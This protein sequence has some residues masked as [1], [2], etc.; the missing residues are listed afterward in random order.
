MSIA[1]EFKTFALRGNL[2]DLAIGVVIG[3]AFGKVVTAFI[4]GLIMPLVGTLTGGV[5]FNNKFIPL[6]AKVAD[7]VKAN[8]TLPLD[9]AKKLGAVWAYGSFITVLIDFLI[10]AFVIFLVI[11]AMNKLQKKEAEAPAATPEPTQSELLLTEIRD[12]LKRQP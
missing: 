5:D 8:P 10:V 3:G 9:E 6:G 7:A 11:K 2:V 4:D 1:K 12:L